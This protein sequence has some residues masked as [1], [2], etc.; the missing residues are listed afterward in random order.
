M[1]VHLVYVFKYQ[2]LQ[3]TSTTVGGSTGRWTLFHVLRTHSS[4]K[5]FPSPSTARDQSAPI[6]QN[7]EKT[8][9]EKSGY[10]YSENSLPKVVLFIHSALYML[11]R[12]GI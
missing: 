1:L 7:H 11:H 9:N 12:C 2:V 3:L 4:L 10:R 8:L 5:S 6:V